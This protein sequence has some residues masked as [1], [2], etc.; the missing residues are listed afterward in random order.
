MTSRA[1][2]LAAVATLS[3]AYSGQLRAQT[4][5]LATSGLWSAYGGEVDRRA[6]CGVTTVGG[7]GRRINVQQYAGQ[8]GVEFA[9]QKETWSIPRDTSIDLRIQFDLNEQ[10]PARAAGTGKQVGFR[11]DFEQSVPF[12]RA[13]RN[14]R[15]VRVFFLGGNE[16]V[17]TGGLSG[18]GRA[19]DAFNDCRARLNP[20]APTE[21]F[22][23]ASQPQATAAPSAPTQPFATPQPS[24]SAPPTPAPLALEPSAQSAPI[25]PQP[26][27]PLP[28]APG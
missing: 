18:S 13:L 2:A 17:W 10:I 16:P 4:S 23:P 15:Q 3:I 14:G 26:L 22:T 5:V 11:M 28:L 24:P 1:L 25:N 12:M 21:P 9:L 19:I 6:V 7:D 27:P 8:S 20:R